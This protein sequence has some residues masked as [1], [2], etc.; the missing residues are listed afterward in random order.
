[1]KRGAGQTQAQ[2]QHPQ[3]FNETISGIH[4]VPCNMRSMASSGTTPPHSLKPCTAV[5]AAG[6]SKGLQTNSTLSD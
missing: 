5:M 1:C 3:A 2:Q 6:F 4:S